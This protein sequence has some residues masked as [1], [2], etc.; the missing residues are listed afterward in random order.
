MDGIGAAPIGAPLP[1]APISS[2]KARKEAFVS[3]LSGGSIMEINLVTLVAPVSHFCSTKFEKLSC[4]LSIQLAILLWSALQARRRFFTPYTLTAF[5]TDF[6][7]NVCAILFAITAY[8]AAPGLLDLLLFL[9]SIVILLLPAS[10]NTVHASK[11]VRK[12]ASDMSTA[13]SIPNRPFLTSY[14]GSMMIVTCLAI[15]AVDFPSFPRRF[16]KC[17]NWGTSLMDLGVGSFVFSAGVVAAR[18]LIKAKLSPNKGG[19]LN[20]TFGSSIF[21]SIRHGL[22]LFVLGMVRLWS[23][24]GLDYAEHVTEY[25]VH[26]NFFF[27][28]AFIPPFLTLAD[29]ILQ[30]LPLS[31][32]TLAIL[33]AA[34]YEGVLDNTRLTAFILLGPRTDLLSKNREGVFSFIGYL[35]IFLAGRGTGLLVLK[36]S[37]TPKDKSKFANTSAAY[38][39]RKDLLQSLLI[40]SLAY[41]IIYVVLTRPFLLGLSLDV[42]RRLANLPYVLWIAA[43]NNAQ[44]LL[45]ALIETFI[46]PSAYQ[47]NSTEDVKDTCPR[48]MQT[49]NSN[50]LAVFLVA[51]LGTGLV[52]LTVNTLD[53]TVLESM[54]IMVLYAAALTAVALGLDMSGFKIKL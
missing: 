39:D 8:S 21:G 49:F 17:E 48:I 28:L 52:N 34:T 6:L 2:Y 11:K 50:G 37:T 44:I 51:N 43:F 9:P 36:P 38:K 31:N 47:S 15:L 13:A 3:D 4:S 41:G 16:G 1:P 10:N 26:W 53:R 33:I 42:S 40:Q 14:R 45:F 22:P 35:A 24:K 7:L 18:P 46:F 32:E 25:G 29:A 5:I 30:F 12:T 54:M 20:D 23:V 27:T 19:P